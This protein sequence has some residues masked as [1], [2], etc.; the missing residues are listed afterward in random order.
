[1][2]TLKF[3]VLKYGSDCAAL[4]SMYSVHVYSM[5]SVHVHYCEGMNRHPYQIHVYVHV[6]C[7]RL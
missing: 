5:Y 6:Y 2:Y 4:Y 1:M 7:I 3:E